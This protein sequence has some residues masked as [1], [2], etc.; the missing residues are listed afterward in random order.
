V[1]GDRQGVGIDHGQ[2]FSKGTFEVQT[3]QGERDPGT[4]GTISLYRIGTII[5]RRRA[6]LGAGLVVGLALG[7]ALALLPAPVYRSK[8][9]FQPQSGQ[10]R[11]SELAIFASS[12]GFGMPTAG[13]S[14]AAMYV[15]L[16]GTHTILEPI[17]SDTLA[18][19]GDPARSLAVAELLQDDDVGMDESID[20]L[21]DL[22]KVREVP[23]IG[24]VEIVVETPRAAVSQAL[25]RRLVAEVNRFNV[26]RR[27][28]QA[29]EE[30]AFVAEQVER[31]RAE[32]EVAERELLEFIQSNRGFAAAPELQFEHDRLQREVSS[33]QRLYTSL[34]DDLAEVRIR[35]VRDTPV[36]TMLEEPVLPSRPVPRHT[37]TKAVLG[38]M[39]GLLVGVLLALV[40]HGW[41]A[42][43]TD[44]DPEAAEF[45][46][47]LRQFLPRP[48]R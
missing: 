40:S 31:T 41:A 7:V 4:G 43:S 2:G 42:A 28:S 9:L 27:R 18:L 14:S 32:L 33:R 6:W 8:A 34:A 30:R 45:T 26:V 13:G 35:E 3:T 1:V 36:I 46:R 19:E 5:L 11:A 17:V 48:R 20:A 23:E 44:G 10:P 16:L 29:T 24:A 39:T 12:F 37:A 47:Q 21:R 15:E 38:M 25:A 22:F